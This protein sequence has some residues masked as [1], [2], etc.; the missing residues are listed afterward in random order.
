[1]GKGRK[2]KRQRTTKTNSS[3][4][5]DDEDDYCG[6]GISPD[7]RVGFK[8]GCCYEQQRH[9]CPVKFNTN[10]FG[11]WQQRLPAALREGFKQLRE[12]RP[13]LRNS[14]SGKFF[15]HMV[16][17]AHEGKQPITMAEV[18]DTLES[19]KTLETWYSHGERAGIASTSLLQHAKAFANIV[20]GLSSAP[21]GKVLERDA[22]IDWHVASSATMKTINVKAKLYQRSEK[23]KLQRNVNHE[24]TGR[25]SLAKLFALNQ[26]Q[27]TAVR[28]ALQHKAQRF[29]KNWGH[30]HSEFTALTDAIAAS[31]AFTKATTY[32]LVHTALQRATDF[33]AF[34]PRVSPADAKLQAAAMAQADVN[35]DHSSHVNLSPEEIAITFKLATA[36]VGT[37]AVFQ[38]KRVTKKNSLVE[39]VLHNLQ[40]MVF[41][42]AFCTNANDRIGFMA[43]L[44]LGEI[45]RAA[46]GQPVQ[47]KR[48][49]RAHGKYAHLRGIITIADDLS[50]SII[51]AYV[52]FVKDV[53]AMATRINP[54]QGYQSAA[55]RDLMHASFVLSYTRCHTTYEVRPCSMTTKGSSERTEA[56]TKLATLVAKGNEQSGWRTGGMG[57]G[58]TTVRHAQ[59]TTLK[60]DPVWKAASEADRERMCAQIGHSASMAQQ[61]RPQ[62]ALFSIADP[63]HRLSSLVC[64][65]ISPFVHTALSVLHGRLPRDPSSCCE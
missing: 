65:C 23:D 63:P 51:V 8:Q 26:A 31:A 43:S 36:A 1:M 16:C 9:G 41:A 57:G 4:F 60:M 34:L 58:M 21:C 24:D 45:A 64:A 56:T 38:A 35:D 37:L 55:P 12:A 33:E 28:M 42:T 6:K 44:T 19:R 40:C 39:F 53:N 29:V 13:A 2:R 11:H 62:H 47:A 52:Q 14:N 54:P 15:M 3:Q 30:L 20:R 22:H 50:R 49:K 48:T 18:K 46:A 7:E 61:V 10:L 32:T 17:I 25:E 5:S 27:W 59:V